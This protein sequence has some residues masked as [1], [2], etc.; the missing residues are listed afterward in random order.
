VIEV[1]HSQAICH[2]RS[3]FPLPITVVLAF[4]HIETRC[5]HGNP[6]WRAIRPQTGIKS[7]VLC[8]HS[9]ELSEHL[10]SSSE[11]C[12]AGRSGKLSRGHRAVWGRMKRPQHEPFFPTFFANRAKASTNSCAVGIPFCRAA[13]SRSSR[14]SRRFPIAVI[15]S[16]MDFASVNATD[17]APVNAR[18]LTFDPDEKVRIR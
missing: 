9:T 14:S 15:A 5:Q 12:I 17:L 4:I 13:R 7:K 18:T 10:V 6:T 16:S 1:H 2:L 11:D 8:K 3:H